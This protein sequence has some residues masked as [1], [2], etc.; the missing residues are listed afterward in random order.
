M[1]RRVVSEEEASVEYRYG[2]LRVFRD[3]RVRLSPRT[4]PGLP[5]LDFSVHY[6]A[7]MENSG[8]YVHDT[9][10]YSISARCPWNSR[11]FMLF[12][13][14]GR[15]VST[16]FHF[17]LT[18]DE[19]RQAVALLRKA[20]GGIER[21]IIPGLEYTHD[22]LARMAARPEFR[23]VEAGNPE[24]RESIPELLQ[25]VRDLPVAAQWKRQRREWER[26]EREQAQQ[27]AAGSRAAPRSPRKVPSKK[28]SR[29]TR[30]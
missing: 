7:E 23:D 30:S 6:V 1:T 4:V 9:E 16:C 25:S 2:S 24:M 5:E 21:W 8:I 3:G 27:A 11:F 20:Q 22:T 10:D 28:T 14:R 19:L 13:S 12:L 29:M 17:G 15:V 26:W 18:P